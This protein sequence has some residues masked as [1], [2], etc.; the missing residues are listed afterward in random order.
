[1]TDASEMWLIRVFVSGIP[2]SDFKYQ[3]LSDFA[4]FRWKLQN[5]CLSIMYSE[6]IT[7]QLFFYNVTGNQ[8]LR[9]SE[10]SQFYLTAEGIVPRLNDV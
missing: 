7:K 6:P 1:M 8:R 3:F 4:L 5:V 2:C 9:S 10:P